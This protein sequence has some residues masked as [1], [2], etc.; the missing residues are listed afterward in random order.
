MPE[1]RRF[2]LPLMAVSTFLGMFL[3]RTMAIGP[4]AFLAGFVLVVTQTLIDVIP[5][6]EA[7]TRFVLWLWVV[8]M[9]PVRRDRP[10][11]PADRPQSD[12]A[13]AAIV[14]PSS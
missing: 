14:A 13:G 4:I 11:Q 1:S 3:L 12:R 6:L 10:G 7:L 8:V 5:N 2:G 9:L